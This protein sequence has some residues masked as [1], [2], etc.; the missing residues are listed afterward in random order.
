MFVIYFDVQLTLTCWVQRYEV[1]FLVFITVIFEDLPSHW[2]QIR[3]LQLLSP[4]SNSSIGVH[5]TFWCLP[6]RR[7]LTR[8]EVHLVL[9]TLSRPGNPSTPPW[10]GAQA[11]MTTPGAFHLS[12]GDLN[13]GSDIQTASP[14]IPW[15]HMIL[16]IFTY[17]QR[18]K[19]WDKKT[20]DW[21]A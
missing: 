20:F 12:S 17:T 11:G 8:S 4:S 18:V 3:L 5:C 9:V 15:D 14:F 1:K 21:N 19:L 7:D 16:C 2:C 10:A 13:S 6:L